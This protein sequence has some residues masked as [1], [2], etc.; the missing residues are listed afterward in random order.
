MAMETKTKNTPMMS[1]LLGLSLFQGL[2]QE[3]L[4]SLLE[5]AVPEFITLTDEPILCRGDRHDRILII[6]K[7]TVT[8]SFT[9]SSCRCTL[10][11][12]MHEGDIIEFTS[13]FGRSILSRAD[14]RAQGEVTLLAFDKKYMFT[15]FNRFEI[16]QMNMLNLYS[17]RVQA[18]QSKLTTNVGTSL[19]ERFCHLV[20][21]LSDNSYGQKALIVSRVHLAELLDCSRRPMSAQIVAWQKAG[22]VEL[23]YGQ[24]IIPDLPRLRQ[25]T[26][27]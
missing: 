18:L 27:K 4:M 6:L 3:Q 24:I 9:D 14:Y 21:A 20:D 10:T 15:T 23:A 25:E 19:G 8:R 5:K 1:S 16:I 17:A 13:L 26:A 11:E 7:G 2:T 22:L 12:Q